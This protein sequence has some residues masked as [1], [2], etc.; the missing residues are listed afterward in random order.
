MS[1]DNK[2]REMF[3]MVVTVAQITMSLR[4]AIR[5]MGPLNDEAQAAMKEVDAFTT[6]FIGRMEK[7]TKIDG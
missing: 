7:W 1:T 3:S 4:S 6:E 2:D 5:A